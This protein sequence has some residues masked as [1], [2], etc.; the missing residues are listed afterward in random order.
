MT[1]QVVNMVGESQN[2]VSNLLKESENILNRTLDNVYISTT[3]KI[4]LGLYAAFAAPKLPK[5]LVDL[6][7]NTIVRVMF[8]FSIVFMATKDPSLAILIAVA[9]II[10]L[11]TANKMRLYNTSMS[12]SGNH[13]NTS[14]LPSAKNGN[15]VNQTGE[16][17]PQNITLNNTLD[18][19]VGL[20]KDVVNT[21]LSVGEDVLQTG[22]KLSQNVVNNVLQESGELLDDIR[23]NL[24]NSKKENKSH[25]VNN[26]VENLVGYNPSIQDYKEVESKDVLL[27]NAQSNNVPGANQRSCVKK[28]ENSHCIQGLESNIPSG[29]EA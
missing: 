4:F 20:V 17:T 7:D 18:S 23:G 19:S 9:F 3:L 14:W 2:V 5:S 12:V 11:Q 27:Q 26:V 13:P 24:S 21:G 15:Y 25:H 6:F 1:E 28:L 8:A 16:Y 29:Y 22:L 10:T